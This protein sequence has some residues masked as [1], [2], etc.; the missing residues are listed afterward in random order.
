MTVP[1]LEKQ[2][3]FTCVGPGPRLATPIRPLYQRDVLQCF[4][5]PL[6]D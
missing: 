3:W 4:S 2:L 1:P 6:K 5:R